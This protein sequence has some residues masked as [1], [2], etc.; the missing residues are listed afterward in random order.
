MAL[1]YYVAE[2]DQEGFEYT[3]AAFYVER[4]V[5]EGASASGPLS[6]AGW[7]TADPNPA[8]SGAEVGYLP[9]GSVPRYTSLLDVSGTVPADDLAP[10]E[11]YLQVLLQDDAY[12]DTWEDARSLMP[13]LLWRGGLE[14]VGPL[15]VFPYAGG[16][17]IAVDFAE[18]RNNRLDSRYTDDLRLTLYATYGYGPAS[19]GYVLCQT[20]A[21]GLY[22]GDT[23]VA[24]GFD[25]V[26]ND[27]PD[28]E[29]TVHLEVAEMGGRGG[30]STLSGPDM[31][32]HGG[33]VDDGYRYG[34][35]AGA[36]A[37]WIA[38]MLLFA[39]IARWIA[40][41]ARALGRRPG[42]VG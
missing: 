37:P 33:A 28:G 29:Y 27:L 1:D 6:L 25:C 24:P 23:R 3:D 20:V 26:L 10:G 32:F 18:L 11:Y 16:H 22:A 13:R 40:P 17:E 2:V 12:P 42:Q 15:T 4:I 8:G 7:A 5:N 14:A 38:V 21:P 31:R 34:V 35:H 9:V 36:L 30:S 39:A 41:R 19:D